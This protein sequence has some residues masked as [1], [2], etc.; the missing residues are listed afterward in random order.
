MAL[1]MFP[2][3]ILLLGL[4][5]LAVHIF[6]IITLQ[7]CFATLPEKHRELSPGLVW[8]LLVPLFN[9]V[10]MFMVVLKLSN[11]FKKAFAER[12]V[13]AEVGSCGQGIGLAY[14]ILICCSIIPIVNFVTG[15][16]ALICWIIYWT[17]M[18]GLKNKYIGMGAIAAKSATGN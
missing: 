6:Y 4:A 15:P 5:I 13:T 8:L 12:G 14:C 17:Q 2:F 7:S 3:L 16:A 1:L 10:W 9:F 11:S 18:A